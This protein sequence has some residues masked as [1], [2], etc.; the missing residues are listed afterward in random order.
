VRGGARATQ[1]GVPVAASHPSARTSAT[2]GEEVD[3]GDELGK[4]VDSELDPS[5]QSRRR[6]PQWAEPVTPTHS[7]MSRCGG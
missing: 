4:L 3:G 5:C 1:A 7:T 2:Q 6:D